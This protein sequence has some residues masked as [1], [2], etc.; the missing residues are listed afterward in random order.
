VQGLPFP[1][2]QADL[3]IIVGDVDGSQGYNDAAM[4]SYQD[5]DNI[6]ANLMER[7]FISG[8]EQSL[9]RYSVMIF[10]SPY[11]YVYIQDL[12][13]H[14]GSTKVLLEPSDF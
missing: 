5:A 2:D 9:A 4:E 1:K 13:C 10:S 12:T 14:L 11:I 3:K 6:L 7:A 8:L